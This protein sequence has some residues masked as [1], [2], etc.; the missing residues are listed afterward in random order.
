[1]ISFY[2]VFNWV[3]DQKGILMSSNDLF[4][5]IEIFF[6]GCSLIHRHW[7]FG[8]KVHVAKKKKGEN[9]VSETNDLVSNQPRV[10]GWF[11]RNCAVELVNPE[12]EDELEHFTAK[13]AN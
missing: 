9:G 7:L 6:S 11:P 13:K 12:S 4:F 3:S 10:R 2:E 1:M 8:E 5:I